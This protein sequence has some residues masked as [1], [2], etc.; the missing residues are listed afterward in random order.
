MSPSTSR[1]PSAR[2][3]WLSRSSLVG[4]SG[5]SMRRISVSELFS[6]RDTCHAA[7][8]ESTSECR[9]GRNAEARRDDLLVG[10][11]A[12]RLRDGLSSLEPNEQGRIEAVPSRWRALPSYPHRRSWPQA[13]RGRRGGST[14]H[15]SAQAGQG[16]RS[17]SSFSNQLGS[18]QVNESY[19]NVR[20]P[21]DSKNCAALPGKICSKESR[22]RRGA[23]AAR[24]TYP[25][26]ALRSAVPRHE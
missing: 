22:M 12:A 9:L 14:R 10:L 6:Q 1:R 24:Q 21:N 2:K 3:A 18:F 25:N 13:G 23:F 17:A 4:C 11:R 19:K 8:S 20:L 5:S 15:R 16:R 26:V 7:L